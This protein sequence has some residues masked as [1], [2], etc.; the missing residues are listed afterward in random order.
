MFSF[1]IS[2]VRLKLVATLF[3]VLFL[4]SEGAAS[5]EHP[6]GQLKL[7]TK[8]WQLAYYE[9]GYHKNYYDYLVAT[10]EGLVNL[11]WIEPIEIPKI[12]NTKRLWGWLANNVKSEHLKF[13]ENNY[14]SAKWDQNLRIKLRQEVIQKVN[15]PN[16]ID[17]IFAMGTW[18]GEDLANNK[19]RTPTFVIS[20]SDP[21]KTGIIQS[22]E[23]SGYK[24]VFA[25][26][27]PQ[28]YEKQIRLFHDLVKFKK[29]GIAYEN[30]KNGEAYAALESV[31]K[32]AK[33]KKFELVSCHTKS[34]IPDGT[35]AT[36]SV[37]SC[38]H[39]LVNEV[40][41]L[42]ITVQ[43]GVN[44]HSIPKIVQIANTKQVAT[45]S[46]QG[47]DEVKYGMLMSV[48]PVGFETTGQFIANALIEVFNG[49]NP[50]DL[51]QIYDVENSVAINLETADKIGTYIYAEWLAV[52]D[53]IYKKI[54]MP[55]S[56]QP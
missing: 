21:V 33:E 13:I 27:S 6:K 2:F 50:G 35:L 53:V 32:I 55:G 56:K 46:Q 4:Y 18:A 40:D 10:V 37:L 3:S 43:N 48:S 42:Y 34:D 52:A 19:H 30:T 20:S 36:S 26:V 9:G 41:A 49:A 16:K 54:S 15:Q 38:V 29:L 5:L 44:N 47:I 39:T 45:L 12:E 22:A 1:F 7:S 8:V 25:R 23:K 28:R 11:G 24:H 17:L 31:T 14:F 51:K